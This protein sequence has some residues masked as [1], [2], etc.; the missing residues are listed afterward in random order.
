M[1]EV[2]WIKMDTSLFDNR[3]IKQIRSMPDGDSLIVIW[4][5]LLCLGGVVNDYG[6]VYLTQ[7][8]PYTD[9]MLATAFD[10]PLA[11]IQLA[12][13]IFRQFGMI[14]IIDDIIF[15]RNWEKYQSIEGLEKVREQTRIRVANFRERHKQ[16][17]CNVTVTSR[18]AD[19]TGQNKNKNKNENKKENIK[20][21][22]VPPDMTLKQSSEPQDIQKVRDRVFNDEEQ[23][24]ENH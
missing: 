22:N 17:E 9:Q 21:K 5:Q 6:R 20:R 11:T 4:L 14:E 2:K 13:N 23:D 24:T 15:I 12:L 8:I 19:V 7:E 16:L 3:K 10:E 18:N 1:N